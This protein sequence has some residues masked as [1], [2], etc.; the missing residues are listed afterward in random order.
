MQDARG[1]RL[2]AKADRGGHLALGTA[3]RRD[4]DRRV[5]GRGGRDGLAGARSIDE[6]PCGWSQLVVERRSEQD[7]LRVFVDEH[8]A[9]PNC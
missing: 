6:F 4:G 1:L 9:D 3:I 7:Q 8:A 2:V 5:A